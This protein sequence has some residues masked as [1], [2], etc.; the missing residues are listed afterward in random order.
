MTDKNLTEIVAILDR[1]GSMESLKSET[2]KGFNAFI[3][4]QKKNPGKALLTLVQFDDQY[5]IDYE[6]VDVNDAHPLDEN[7]Y[8]PRGW[9]ALFDAVGKTVKTVGERLA[10]TD[11]DKRPG[12][13]IFVIVTDGVENASKEFVGD[14][15]REMVK[16]QEEN[17]QW[18]FV[19]LGG[20]DLSAQ[21]QQ[22]RHLGISA[23]NTY[24]YSANAVG[25]QAM[26]ANVSKGV[27]R[28]RVA[29]F[30]GMEVDTKGAIL[31]DDEKKELINN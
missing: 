24:G 18:T 15:I 1:S 12:Q 28:R 25:T 30:K 10:K 22:G 9:T 4:E 16:H 14:K 23:S 26:Y 20:G 5:Q 17:Y 21:T 19:F 11:E 2:I 13:V 27:S 7:S 8:C 31:T 6:G 29:A 3:S